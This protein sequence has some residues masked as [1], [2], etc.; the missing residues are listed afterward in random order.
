MVPDV[1]TNVV[2]LRPDGQ[3]DIVEWLEDLLAKAKSGEIDAVAVAY[4]KPEH[5]FVTG[6]RGKENTR[7]RLGFATN[8]L[9]HRYTAWVLYGEPT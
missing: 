2:N 4:V 6:W 9:S 1:M 8:A 3:D 5:G 7:D